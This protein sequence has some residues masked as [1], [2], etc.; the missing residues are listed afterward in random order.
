MGRTHRVSIITL[1]NRGNVQ[2]F[3][4][5]ALALQ[6]KYTVRILSSREHGDFVKSFNIEFVDVWGPGFYNQ[7]VTGKHNLRDLKLSMETNAN[8]YVN[9]VLKDFKAHRPN[10]ILA[11]P[12]SEYFEY[13][14]RFYLRIP[15]LHVRLGVLYVNKTTHRFH[16]SYQH[17][18]Y[19]CFS[20]YDNQMNM[21]GRPK[22]CKNISREQF[23]AESNQILNGI[24]SR[25]IVVCQAAL[26]YGFAPVTLVGPCFIN[27]KLEKLC[28]QYFGGP[29]SRD[30]IDKFME[31]NKDPEKIPVYCG[32]GS[33]HN[34][35]RD[36]IINVVIAL[37]RIKK[38]GVILIPNL[39]KDLLN[40][41][42]P[43]PELKP[44]FQ[45]NMLLLRQA[46]HGYLF[47]KVQCVVHHG[48]IGTSLAAL[49]AGVPSV[50]VHEFVTIGQCYEHFQ[51]MIIWHNSRLG[52]VIKRGPE[53]F[54]PDA[55]AKAILIVTQNKKILQQCQKVGQQLKGID[56]CSGLMKILDSMTT[57]QPILV[58]PISTQGHGQSNQ[59]E[60]CKKAAENENEAQLQQVEDDDELTE[61]ESLPDHIMFDLSSDDE[62]VHENV[63]EAIR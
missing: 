62:D 28:D 30:K 8:R 31:E 17:F 34:I 15:T 36:T 50:I 20:F 6:P 4:A 52:F 10:I 32:W 38:R 5:I 63:G 35:S 33:N 1:G 57:K 59:S 2:P 58:P 55:L 9:S 47:P 61:A 39:S 3:V 53:S 26:Y 51:Q 13:F 23:I 16:D 46:P 25:K 45:N 12:F 24:G 42:V 49:R 7:L 14:A 43:Y 29:D 54:E 18:V 44:Y 19:D 48:G 56:G 21:L 22:V 11:G 60:D 27:T 41:T 37:F 40:F